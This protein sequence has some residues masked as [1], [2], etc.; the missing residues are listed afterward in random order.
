VRAFWEQAAPELGLDARFIDE[1]V[2]R[3]SGNLQHA[4][5]L[6]LHLAG[7][8]PEQRRVEDIPR[9]LGLC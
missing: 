6:R 9:R 5:M 1:A 3:A 7:L 4:A 2:A 8:A